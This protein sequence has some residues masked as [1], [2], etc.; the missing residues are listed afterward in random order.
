MPHTQSEQHQPVTFSS[1]IQIIRL[2]MQPANYWISA[3]RRT[4]FRCGE[5]RNY[6]DF[7]DVEL[8]R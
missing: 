5:Q 6:G 1:S 7:N 2:F 3:R 8:W 4:P